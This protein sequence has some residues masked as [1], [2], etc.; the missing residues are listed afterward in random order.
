MNLLKKSLLY[1]Y[2]IFTLCYSNPILFPAKILMFFRQKAIGKSQ[3]LR[4][5]TVLST[6]FIYFLICR[7]LWADYYIHNRRNFCS[8]KKQF[9]GFSLCSSLTNQNFCNFFHLVLILLVAKVNDRV[10]RVHLF[11]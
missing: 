11:V 5:S 6:F 3:Q 10:V 7:N 4:V 1:I 9:F 2:F 8:T